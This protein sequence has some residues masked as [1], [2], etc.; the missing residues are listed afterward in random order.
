M[1]DSKAGIIEAILK[2]TG[3]EPTKYFDRLTDKSDRYLRKLLK[4][5]RYLSNKNAF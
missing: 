3:V 2:N 1:T 4:V 5:T